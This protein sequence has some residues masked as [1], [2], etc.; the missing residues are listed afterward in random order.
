[1]FNKFERKYI[2]Y[3]NIIF[4]VEW[5]CAGYDVWVIIICQTLCTIITD[6]YLVKQN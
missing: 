6:A 1:V 2:L 4:D 5:M 3:K